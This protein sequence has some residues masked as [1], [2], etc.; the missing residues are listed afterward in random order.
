[1]WHLNENIP[2]QLCT[3]DIREKSKYSALKMN[4]NVTWKKWKNVWNVK[5]YKKNWHEMNLS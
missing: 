2:I 4:R 1:M 3:L 5:V